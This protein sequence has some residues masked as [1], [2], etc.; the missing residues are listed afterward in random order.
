MTSMISTFTLLTFRSC[1]L[2]Y[3]LAPFMAQTFYSVSDMQ[4]SAHIMMTL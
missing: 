1:Q 2:T 4:D 3:H